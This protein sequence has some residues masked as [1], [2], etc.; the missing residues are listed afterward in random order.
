[1]EKEFVPYE[2]ALKMKQLGFDEPCLAFYGD[3]ND[4]S[5]DSSRKNNPFRKT[6]C[7]APLF[8]QAFRW[9]RENHNLRG[10]IGFRPNIKQFDC[11]IYDMSLSGKEYVKQRTMEEFNKDPK[12]GTYE[13]AEL[14]CLEK[15]IEIVKKK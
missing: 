12:V 5:M 6:E 8:Q 2:L 4:F 3:E 1:M 7:V 15:L 10:F 9:F 14:A 13:E 11:H